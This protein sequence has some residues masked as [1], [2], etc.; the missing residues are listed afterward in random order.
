MKKPYVEK[1]L[2]DG[3]RVRVFPGR[4]PQEMMKWHQDGEGR[5]IRLVGN[6]N[7]WMFQFD[8]EAPSPL[9]DG[10]FVPKHVWHRLLPGDGDLVVEIRRER[11]PE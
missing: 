11:K 10:L 5:E 1:T 7:G 2:D 9:V 8:N 6:A 3:R 4:C